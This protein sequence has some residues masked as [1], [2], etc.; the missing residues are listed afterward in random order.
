ML[1][2]LLAGAADGRTVRAELD[3]LAAL[4]ES[5][6]SYEERK[7]AAALNRLGGDPVE[8]LGVTPPGDGDIL[9]RTETA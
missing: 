6:F 1:V 3:G 4:L 5:H 9:E 2:A 7:L 8:L